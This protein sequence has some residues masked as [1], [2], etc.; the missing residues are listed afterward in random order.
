MI[1]YRVSFFGGSG[2]IRLYDCGTGSA[3]ITT[4]KDSS[5]YEGLIQNGVEVSIGIPA[6][7][8]AQA[9][10]PISALPEY[11]VWKEMTGRI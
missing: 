2:A 5:I 4:D 11:R 9:F 6:A 8:S 1:F 3:G 10:P 7:E